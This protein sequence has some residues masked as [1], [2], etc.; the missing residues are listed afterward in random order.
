MQ[1]LPLRRPALPRKSRV[2]PS[3]RRARPALQACSPGDSLRRTPQR[4][5]SRE[6]FP[7][8]SGRAVLGARS[9]PGH[10]ATPLASA[11]DGP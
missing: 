8:L 9:L 2:R 1:N 6:G 5:A 10:T 7:A 4:R 3:A 11:R